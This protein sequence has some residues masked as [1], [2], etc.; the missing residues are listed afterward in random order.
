MKEYKLKKIALISVWNH[1]YGSLLQTYALQKYLISK[2]L[3]NEIILYK[4]K[5]VFR[6]LFRFTNFS[7]LVSKIK[8]IYRKYYLKLFY[9][10]ISK[11]LEIRANKF[12]VFK[13]TRLNFSKP[14]KGRRKL[15]VQI[16]NYSS[17]VLGSDQVLHPANLLMNYFTLSFVPDNIMKIAYAPSFGVSNIP[18]F[19]IKRTIAYLRKFKSLSVREESGKKI[20]KKLTGKDVPLV[21]D[22]TLLLEFKYWQQLRGEVP[23]ITEKYIFCYFLGKNRKHREFANKV[24]E[25]TGYKIITLTHLIEFVKIDI[26]FSDA[27]PFDVGPSEFINLISN[28]EY[29]LTDSFHGSIFSI[30]FN[31]DFFVFKRFSDGKSD[32][33]N[34]R[35][36][37]LLNSLGLKDRN[38]NQFED[39]TSCLKLKINYKIVNEKLDEF[40]KFSENYLHESLAELD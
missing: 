23:I 22:P 31:K 35:I 14:I 27:Q 25:N 37:S 4:E 1:N 17:V 10:E 16:A 34:S 24:K 30:L 28:A 11:N 26:N 19:Q 29:I 18:L 12:D 15:K 6:K 8:I 33:T 7:Y 3:Q 13:N 36:D 21:C 5:N 39:V 20:V 38:L 40:R 9:H 2:K 32:S